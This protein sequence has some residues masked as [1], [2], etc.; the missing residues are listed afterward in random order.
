[1][2]PACPV[3]VM[4]KAP[5][6]GY[7]KTR[8]IPTLGSD[9][10]ARLAE[11]LLE[12]AADQALKAALGPVEICCAPHTRHRAFERLAGQEGVA[13]TDQGDGDLGARMARALGRALSGSVRRALL[14]GTDAPALDASVLR[15]AA[16]ELDR[17][18]AVFVPAL[19][20]GYALI[21]L[22]RSVP[23]LF[24]GIAWGTSSVMAA[25]RERLVQAR[26]RHAE[27]APVHDIDEPAD[28]TRLPPD[29]L[30]C[31]GASL[32]MAVHRI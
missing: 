22:R 5:V 9:G 30:E 15:H 17:H 20:G 28:L 3:I 8:L 27:L 12:R 13:L 10:A 2:M 7:A 6:A 11:R 16:A 31:S 26:L 1:M 32:S 18:D 21:G 4:A 19:D 29:W 24:D 23:S 25:T 14:I